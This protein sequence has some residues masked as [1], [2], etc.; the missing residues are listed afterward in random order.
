M[1]AVTRATLRASFLA[2]ALTLSLAACAGAPPPPSGPVTAT[3]TYKHMPQLVVDV[4]RVELVEAWRQPGTLPHIGHRNTNS[5]PEIIRAWT[6]D[7]LRAEPGGPG[8]RDGSTLRVIL[9]NGAVTRTNLKVAEGVGGIFQDE[10]DTRIE[11]IC[12]VDV[13]LMDPTAGRIGGISVQVSGAR[14]ILESASLNDRDVIY[15]A[16]MEELASSL[17]QELENGLRAELGFVIKR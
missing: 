11:A 2:A 7:R 14:N 5:P 1:K 4:A 3:I 17:N 6:R 10:T 9:R 16:L 8:A 15:F 13:E 12:A